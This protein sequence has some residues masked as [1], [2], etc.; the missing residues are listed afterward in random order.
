MVSP[1]TKP[2]ELVQR[3]GYFTTTYATVQLHNK[4]KSTFTMALNK[5][6]AMVTIIFVCFL[7]I[8]ELNYIFLFE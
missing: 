1:T 6:S 3:K 2:E 7:A 5:F 8:L 4:K